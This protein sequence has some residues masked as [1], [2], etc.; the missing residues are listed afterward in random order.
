ME[1]ALSS[2]KP[3]VF[4]SYLDEVGATNTLW[5]ELKL[6]LEKTLDSIN[7]DKTDA[8]FCALLNSLGKNE[9]ERFCQRLNIANKKRD[10]ALLVNSEKAAWMN[11]GNASAAD[12]INLLYR[13]DAFRK[14]DR[15]MKFN[16]VCAALTSKN[17]EEQ[18]ARLYL[19]ARE[20]R[21]KTI[22]TKGIDGPGLGAKLKAKRIAKVKIRNGL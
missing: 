13:A 21:L 18:W 11:L 9:I 1:K 20:T 6:K 22:E 17:F 10:L 12:I 19:E 3:S 14:R 8:R 4:F 5:P 7:K 16:T 15:F 2:N